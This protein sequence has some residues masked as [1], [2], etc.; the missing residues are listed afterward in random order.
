MVLPAGAA[1]VRGVLTPLSLYISSLAL[2]D[3]RSRDDGEAP[4]SLLTVLSFSL[5]LMSDTY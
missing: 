3:G 2:M 1:K 4:G 5:H